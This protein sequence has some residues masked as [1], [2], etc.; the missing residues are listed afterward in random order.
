MLADTN[1]PLPELFAAGFQVRTCTKGNEAFGESR[2]TVQGAYRLVKSADTEI[3]WRGLVS[4]RDDGIEVLLPLTIAELDGIARA[5]RGEEGPA[6]WLGPG[7]LRCLVEGL[8]VGDTWAQVDC[9]LV[10]VTPAG[11]FSNEQSRHRVDSLSWDVIGH[12]RTLRLRFSG[13][14][15]HATNGPKRTPARETVSVMPDWASLLELNDLRVRWGRTGVYEQIE[16]FSLSY[17]RSC[18]AT[19]S[20]TLPT[21]PPS[22]WSC[23]P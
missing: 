23:K 8:E 22:S 5:V 20:E 7:R 2:M 16:F 4:L 18:T 17:G 6:Q 19:W 12:G 21:E 10:P 14:Q 11:M 3:G 13:Y 9:T 1:H 15:L